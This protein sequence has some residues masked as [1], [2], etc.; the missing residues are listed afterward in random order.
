MGGMGG[1]GGRQKRNLADPDEDDDEEKMIL[2]NLKIKLGVTG[3]DEGKANISEILKERYMDL[4]PIEQ[5]RISLWLRALSQRRRLREDQIQR[6]Q[7]IEDAIDLE[8]E[9][10][11]KK[12][13]SAKLDDSSATENHLGTE[14]GKALDNEL[15]TTV[16]P[17]EVTTTHESYT[18]PDVTTVESEISE[19][20][21]HVDGVDMEANVTAAPMTTTS[22]ETSMVE[23]AQNHT[24]ANAKVLENFL[25]LPTTWTAPTVELNPDLRLAHTTAS[26]SQREEGS[27]TTE[28]PLVTTGP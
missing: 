18:T 4:P 6:E 21:E 23:S 19:I 1:F 25:E 17:N 27:F 8:H 26:A 5:Y 10:L 7:A 20:P 15:G 16:A 28:G 12:Y 13:D 2:D 22:N 3:E 9:Y 14:T 11:S 24:S